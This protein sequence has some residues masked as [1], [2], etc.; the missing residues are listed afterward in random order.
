MGFDMA[1]TLLLTPPVESDLDAMTALAASCTHRPLIHALIR[2]DLERWLRLTPSQRHA[3]LV[4][5]QRRVDAVV[6]HPE[7]DLGI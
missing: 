1:A 6:P 5:A 7:L 4:R 3:A 2:E